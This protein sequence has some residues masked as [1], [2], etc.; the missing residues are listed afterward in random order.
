MSKLASHHNTHNEGGEGFNPHEAKMIAGA[1]D[2]AEARIQ[3]IIAN[4]D[5]YKAA[6]NVAVAKHTK[7]GKVDMAKLADIEREAGVTMLEMQTVKAR[8]A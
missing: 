6:W 8:M 2:K 5:S 1:Y 4:L 3:H 7:A